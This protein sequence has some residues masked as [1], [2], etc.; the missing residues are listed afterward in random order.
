M[1]TAFLCKRRHLG[2]DV[3]P[4]CYARLYEIPFLL[5][6]LGH[7]VRGFCPSYQGHD[8]GEREHQ[9]APAS[10]IMGRGRSR[11]IRPQSSAVPLQLKQWQKLE[12][13]KNL[14]RQMGPLQ[15]FW[16]PRNHPAYLVRSV[17]AVGTKRG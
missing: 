5:A 10:R 16:D 14:P 1:R 6:R 15:R 17:R 8:D 7:D 12:L 4:D 11:P 3:I 2:K 9:A 13:G